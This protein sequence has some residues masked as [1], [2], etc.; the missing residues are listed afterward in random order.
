[1][2]KRLIGASV[3]IGP[4]MWSVTLVYH[5]RPR[6]RWGFVTTKDADG[7]TSGLSVNGLVVG[8]LGI[9][10]VAHYQPTAWPPD[11]EDN[12]ATS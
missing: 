1:M 7:D 3:C 2:D 10:I 12:D 8:D 11:M 9:W 4:C 5:R 6:F